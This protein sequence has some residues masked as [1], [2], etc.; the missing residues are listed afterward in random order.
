MKTV[1][2]EKTGENIDRMRRERGVTVSEIRDAAGLSAISGIY[3]WFHGES[4]P[5][6]DNLVILADLFGVGIGDIV[7]TRMI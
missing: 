1:D 5:T 6:V 4:L 2:M 3:K 7:A